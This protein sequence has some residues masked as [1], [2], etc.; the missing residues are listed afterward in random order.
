VRISDFGR[1]A[2]S[3]C[4]VA[5]MLAGCGG[6]Q[7]PGGA[8]GAMPQAHL[9]QSTTKYDASAPLLF[10]TNTTDNE[11]A[12]Y[13]AA[14]KNPDPIA[15]ITDGLEFPFGDCI[16]S[17][18]TLYVTNAGF[19][20]EGYVSEYAAGKTKVTR[21]ITK[22]IYLPAYCAIDGAGDLWVTNL[23]PDI[24][25]TGHVT[26]YE[27]G[28]KKPSRTI[29]D[30]VPDPHGIAFDRSGNMFV[31]N[32]LGDYDG[33][34]VVYTPGRKSPSRTIT[35]G[36][37]SAAGIAVDAKGTLYVADSTQCNIEE[38]LAGQDHPYR[39]IT[40]EIDFPQ[41]LTVGK[42]GWLYVTNT[43]DTTCKDNGPEPVILEF[44]PGSLKPSHKEV[45]D[46]VHKPGGSAYNPPLLP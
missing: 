27:K 8:T 1:Y 43:G 21:V 37:G 20:E 6:S 35:N 4:A 13:D 24:G 2:L 45:S 46:E 23:G 39:E 29:T 42:N 5:A 36:L 17:D 11:V 3:S 30:G 19:N 18:G 25:I 28:S 32:Y 26:E 38:Y 16:D 40:D 34:V 9:A 7:P 22:G 14:A 33:N 10:V 12:V 41:G 15:V 44:A 31:S